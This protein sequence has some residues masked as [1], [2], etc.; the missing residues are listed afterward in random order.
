MSSRIARTSL[1]RLITDLQV[2][3]AETR[4]QEVFVNGAFSVM[5]RPARS[6]LK[7][8]NGSDAAIGA[9]IEP[10]QR[11]SGNTNQIAGFDFD[12][13]HVSGFG[14]NMKKPVTSDRESDFV[15]VVPVLAIKL[16]QHCVEPG[17]CGADVDYISS[18]VAAAIFQLFDFARVS[19]E[20]CFGRRV[21][22]DWV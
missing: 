13:K 7:Q 5:R 9:E 10:V 14:M 22:S 12:T 2:R 6:V 20:D 17:C 21:V 8:T 1:S 3:G 16:R 4:Q 18:H 19:V 11:A 15:L